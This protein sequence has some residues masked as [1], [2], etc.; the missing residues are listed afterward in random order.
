M[1]ENNKL[2]TNTDSSG[3]GSMLYGGGAQPQEPESGQ[4][5]AYGTEPRQP[6]QTHP[7]QLAKS[8]PQ[9][10]DPQGTAQGQPPQGAT[11]VQLAK[12]PS[13]PEQSQ[14]WQPS[15]MPQGQFYQAGNGQPGQNPMG[16]GPMQV[17]PPVQGAPAARPKKNHAGLVVGILCAAAVVIVVA[18]G[19]LAAKSFLGGGGP[20]KQ[21]AKGFANMGREMAAYQSSVAKDIGLADL[22]RLKETKPMRTSIDFSFTDPSATGSITS[23]A[24][25]VDGVTDYKKKMAKYDVSLGTYGINMDIG[26]II[27][28]DNTLYVSV[29]IVFHEEVYSLDL[30]NLGRDFNRSAWASLMEETLPEDYGLTL[31]SGKKAAGAE[32][33]RESELAKIWDRQRSIT[34]DSMKF[35]TIRQKREF[36]F[37]GT[38]AE[39]GGVRV[40]MDKDA[41]NKSM[42]AMRD[43]I[44]ASDT[45]SAFMEGY[46]T[47]YAGD[48]DEFKKEMDYVIGQ[49]FGLRLEQDFVADFYLDKKGRIV[50]ISTPEDIPVSGQDMDIDSFAIDIDFSGTER[51]LDS[52]EGGIYMQS[53]DEILYMGISRTAV[54]TEDYYSED[55]TLRLQEDSSDDELTF[56]YANDWG[57]DDQTFDLKMAL[58]VPGTSLRFTAE[59][60]YTD[61]VKGEGYTFRLDH[62]TITV[63]D[64]DL[65]LMTGSIETEPTDDVIEVPEKATNVL[66]MSESD[67]MSLFYGMLQ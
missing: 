10:P 54:I 43:D 30:T 26:S 5:Y 15:P 65:L 55:L 36:T 25:G 2:E 14:P 51:A 29:P 58:E 3:S 21:L 50:N 46:R 37:D 12:Q 47:T 60:A 42:E 8:S 39:Y 20:E 27:A 23:V 9:E 38:F 33:A 35:E 61:I 34:A 1:E 66:E 6:E 16:F 63:D 4:S 49:L 52:I 45:Y 48:F 59:G 19:A 57:Y 44:L 13:V 40:T 62:G 56:W 11:P 22:N 17:P 41:Y 28:A 67:I 7:V 64:E 32:K 31:F 24:F 18:I 53:G